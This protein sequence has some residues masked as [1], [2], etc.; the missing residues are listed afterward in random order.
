V[1]R[2]AL[3]FFLVSLLIV[4][5]ISLQGDPGVANLTWLGWRVD[6]T[7]AAGVLIIGLLALLA[8]IFWRVL[9]WIVAAP[10]RAARARDAASARR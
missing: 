3:A 4:V 6:T 2:I 1:I 5:A 10:S 7:A 9:L 8:T